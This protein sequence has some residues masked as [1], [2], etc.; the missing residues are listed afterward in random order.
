[1]RLKPG[2]GWGWSQINRNNGLY[3]A[4]SQNGDNNQLITPWPP[5]NLT[6]KTENNNHP[7]KVGPLW[8]YILFWL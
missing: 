8:G 1:M 7:F 5:S 6:V 2:Q 3:S 4:F